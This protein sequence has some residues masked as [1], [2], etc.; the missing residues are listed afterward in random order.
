MSYFLKLSEHPEWSSDGIDKIQTKG[1]HMFRTPESLNVELDEI[2]ENSNFT[3]SL[4]RLFKSNEILNFSF[5][6]HPFTRL[7]SCYTDKILNSAGGHYIKVFQVSK[8][9]FVNTTGVLNS[10]FIG[11]QKQVDLR[12]ALSNRKMP[13]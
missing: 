11:D 5:V 2:A 12:N 10:S 6:R 1:F 3:Q 4:K 9:Y 7:V 8:M 13:S